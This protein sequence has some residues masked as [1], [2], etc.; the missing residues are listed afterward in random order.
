VLLVVDLHD[1][2]DVG[3]LVHFR[4]AELD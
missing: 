4:R 1:Q 3:L 2:L